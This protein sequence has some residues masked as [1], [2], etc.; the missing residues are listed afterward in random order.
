MAKAYPRIKEW[1]SLQID[2][3]QAS[4]DK[5]EKVLSKTKIAK[6][7]GYKTIVQW[8]RK[9]VLQANVEAAKRRGSPRQIWAEHISKGIYTW[10]I[11]AWKNGWTVYTERLN[12]K[13]RCWERL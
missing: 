7:P 13:F 9:E 2:L 12:G 11:E 10:T 8:I 6:Q 5:A 3:K 4:P 1:L